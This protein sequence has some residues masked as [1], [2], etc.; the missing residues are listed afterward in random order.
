[1]W[2]FKA[3]DEIWDVAISED[4]RYVVA[5]SRDNAIYF[6]NSLGQLLSKYAAKYFVSSVST[7]STGD[8]AVAGSY[9]NNLYY[10]EKTATPPPKPR[11][12]K[13]VA[14]KTAQSKDLVEGETTTIEI[15]LQNIGDG[16]ARKVK[17]SDAVPAGFELLEGETSWAGELEPGDVKVVTYKIKAAKLPGR[18]RITYE[19]P[20][21]NVT[22]ED[23][24]GV[25]YSFKGAS[26]LITVTPKIAPP[27]APG[28]ALREKLRE[29]IS[30]YVDEVKKAGSMTI[31]LPLGAALLSFALVFMAVRKRRE[32]AFRK[33]KVELLRRLRG[34]MGAGMGTDMG[35]A[36][37]REALQ[38]KA[39]G[40]KLPS[41]Y[42]DYKRET[43]NLIKNIKTLI[44]GERKPLGIR[45]FPRQPK[46]SLHVSIPY[47]IKS[48]VAKTENKAYREK[49]VALLADIKKAMG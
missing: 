16:V 10:F 22:Y 33:E 20:E 27:G 4:G 15:T 3:K 19:L 40:P 45:T 2:K 46:R 5:G 6:L 24:R 7:S 38:R 31:I 47:W 35:Y 23:S 13:I 18:E 39:P 44:R 9:D 26:I 49:N 12:P 42:R 30:S 21:V 41:G 25:F 17:L 11:F 32:R 29:K 34:E 1:L 28:L 43:L 14:L 36:A 37:P 48:L 8:Y